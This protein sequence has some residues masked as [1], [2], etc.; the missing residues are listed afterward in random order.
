MVSLIR[1]DYCV[2]NAASKSHVSFFIRNRLL[3]NHNGSSLVQ[4]AGDGPPPKSSLEVTA[5]VDRNGLDCNNLKTL[6]DQS[7]SVD[8]KAGAF[9]YEHYV[10]V[11]SRMSIP[12]S[13]CG[14]ESVRPR[15]KK[16]RK[17]RFVDMMRKKNQKQCNSLPSNDKK[18]NMLQPQNHHTEIG[19]E[20]S[21]SN[22]SRDVVEKQPDKDGNNLARRNSQEKI[23]S[24]QS[25]AATVSK[26]IPSTVI[27]DIDSRKR[28]KYKK[29]VTSADNKIL[30]K[31][32]Q[33]FE[34]IMR[35]LPVA[36]MPL[37]QFNR[38][39]KRKFRKFIPRLLGESVIQT[40]VRAA[41][42]RVFK[43]DKVSHRV[44]PNHAGLSF[45][46]NLRELMIDIPD[47]GVSLSRINELYRAKFGRFIPRRRQ[48]ESLTAVLHR[49][50][51]VGI[52]QLQS[53]KFDIWVVRVKS[54]NNGSKMS[55]DASQQSHSGS[56]SSQETTSSAQSTAVVNEI[57]SQSSSIVE[58][59]NNVE[60]TMMLKGAFENFDKLVKILPAN[61]IHFRQFN[62]MYKK[63]FG[64]R[65]PRPPGKTAVYTLMR[66]ADAGVLQ[67]DKVSFRVFPPL[68]KHMSTG[69]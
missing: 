50:A 56:S 29:Y 26:P 18:A 63:R 48:G 17:I 35:Y 45:Y 2:K 32:F 6:L 33:N 10:Q 36:G 14:G 22:S 23:V 49:A 66:A 31:A 42:A 39:Y 57:D 40:I 16:P 34:K 44:F 65:V 7:A 47:N 37:S 21:K 1:L 8:N 67:W 69:T 59:G 5:A 20:A 41:E 38:L 60:K 28:S 13:A 30:Q 55:T 58:N 52:C 43:F 4:S 11:V 25:A 53:R 12:C 64:M 24:A 54:A 61:G 19:L 3:C 9:T 27:N 68:P 51:N 46:W 15:K 62:D